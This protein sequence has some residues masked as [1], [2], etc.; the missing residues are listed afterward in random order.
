M[1]F[2]LAM[3]LGLRLALPL[4]CRLLIYC[5]LP[6][7]AIGAYYLS[8]DSIRPPI[9]I[10]A[11]FLCV[12]IIWFAVYRT[13]YRMIRTRS[14]LFCQIYL[15][16]LLRR[17]VSEGELE[18]NHVEWKVIAPL[19][20]RL[21]IACI[22]GGILSGILS[23]IFP[24][25]I[26]GDLISILLVIAAMSYYFAALLKKRY[27]AYPELVDMEIINTETRKEKYRIWYYLAGCIFLPELA[28]ILLCIFIVSLSIIPVSVT[29]EAE[30]FFKVKDYKPEENGYYAILGLNSGA[31]ALQSGL[32]IAKELRSGNK[33]AFDNT[34]LSTDLAQSRFGDINACRKNDPDLSHKKSCRSLA[35]WQPVIEENKNILSRYELL[36][37]YHRF[38]VPSDLSP[39][40]GNKYMRSFYVLM[41]LKS[42]EHVLKAYSGESEQALKDWLVDNSFKRN[43]MISDGLYMVEFAELTGIYRNDL[44]GLLYI[45]DKNPTLIQKYKNDILASFSFINPGDFDFKKPLEGDAGAL[46]KSGVGEMVLSAGNETDKKSGPFM[47][48]L[49]NLIVEPFDHIFENKDYIL[50]QETERALDIK[51]SM[52]RKNALDQ[53]KKKYSYSSIRPVFFFELSDLIRP[54]PSAMARLLLEG[55]VNSYDTGMIGDSYY[56]VNRAWLAYYLALSEG[57]YPDSMDEFLKNAAAHDPRLQSVFFNRPF[58]WNEK[59][60]SI[61]YDMSVQKQSYDPN[62]PPLNCISTDLPLEH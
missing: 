2:R 52:Q 9:L 53:I 11:L 44:S 31:D 56:T 17:E 34:L 45:L 60:H 57:A 26:G 55:F 27:A 10:A 25:M 38:D 50:L 20:F 40:D 28:G 51:D 18:K 7:P 46:I 37:Q 13:L 16:L 39:V 15:P 32:Q 36:Y 6:I 23:L 19:L 21:V 14:R 33:K 62:P 29:P 4:Y 41:E 42:I 58:R 24:D 30:A 49:Q 59:T 54:L 48:W 5:V 47:M 35:A 43:M 3:R 22:A 1:N 61:C 8:D 12:F